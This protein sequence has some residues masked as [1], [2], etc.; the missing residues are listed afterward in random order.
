V[1]DI[2]TGI[3][4]KAL[5]GVAGSDRRRF[6]EAA[7]GGGGGISFVLADNRPELPLAY[8]SVWDPLTPF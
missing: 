8:L 7:L 1:F 4:G 6:H 3:V 5:G 2:S